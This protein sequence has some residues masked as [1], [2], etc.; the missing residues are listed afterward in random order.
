MI[1]DHIDFFMKAFTQ[2]TKEESDM[3]EEILK[4]DSDKK[5]AFILAK[6]LFEDKDD[7]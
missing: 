4:W 3:I 5:T 2:I 1:K 7:N 6:R